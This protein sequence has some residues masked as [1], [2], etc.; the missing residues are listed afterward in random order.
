MAI[1]RSRQSHLAA[2]A[3]LLP[4]LLLRALIPAGFMPAADPHG[5]LALQMCSTGTSGVVEL[6]RVDRDSLL[7]TFD[8]LEQTPLGHGDRP[9]PCDF[10]LASLGAA[11]P[12]ASVTAVLATLE[13]EPRSQP[14]RDRL[15]VAERS[16]YPQQ[17]RA[18]PHYS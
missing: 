11:P 6:P 10:A 2:L 17:P 15:P 18:P 3:L 4:A 14:L 13:R 16:E 8:P 1:A 12:P 5:V 7:H 9:T